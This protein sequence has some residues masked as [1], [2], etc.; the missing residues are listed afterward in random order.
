M[1]VAM[2][3]AYVGL[4]LAANTVW[5]IVILPLVVFVVDR[6]VIAREERYLTAKFGDDYEAYR[7]RVRR[8][9]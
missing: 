2:A 8:W 1:Y 6:Y 7:R 9:V 3:V 4:S 5:P